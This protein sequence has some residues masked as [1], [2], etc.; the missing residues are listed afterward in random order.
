MA[1]V[2]K[3]L[4]ASLVAGMVCVGCVPGTSGTDTTQQTAQK[5]GEP[6]TVEFWTINLK[7]NYGEYVEGL[8][9]GFEKSHD[10][11]TIKWVDVPGTDVESKL[12]AALATDDVPDAVNIEDMRVDQFGESLSDLTPYFDQDEL[13][14][15]I[16]GLVESVRRDDK[17]L[18]IPWYNGGAPVAWYNSSL[19]QEAGVG[20]DDLPETWDE[21]LDL[22]QQVAQRTDA[23]AF[24]ALPTLDVLLSNGAEPLSADRTKPALNTPENAQVLEKFRAAYKDGTICPGAVS[25]NIRNLP[26]TVA[27]GMAAASV[28]GLPFQLLDIEK[29]AAKTYTDLAVGHAVTGT[30]GDFIIGGMQTFA[31][32]AK[33]DVKEQA[34]EFI[35]YVTSAEAQLEF[36]K[37]VTIFPSTKD[38]LEDP[39]FTDVEV[40]S[41]ADAARKA[42]VEELPKVKTKDLG[43]KVDLELDEAYLERI[44]AYMTGDQ[45]AADALAD[46]EQDWT[47]LLSKK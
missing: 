34:A 33:S 6:V 40:K 36:C 38:T 27:N 25:E 11:I 43:T 44:R 46:V 23:C 15:Y 3:L 14:P 4:A 16:D 42:V 45:A 17:L 41:P 10:D 39:F 35:E 7:K 26:Q 5:S 21:A 18:A 29:N 13:A 1:R 20:T 9:D 2:A 22:G 24:N 12:L 47:D 31:I 30:T 28:D 32:P 8:I 37:L 19:L